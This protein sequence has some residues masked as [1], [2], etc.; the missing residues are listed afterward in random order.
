[1]KLELEE[2]LAMRSQMDEP[3]TIIELIEFQICA[4][5]DYVGGVDCWEQIAD[6]VVILR[7]IK[8]QNIGIG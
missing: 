7:K 6:F 5:H 3:T 2:I 1:L 4:V 8:L